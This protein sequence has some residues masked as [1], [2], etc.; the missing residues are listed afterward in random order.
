MS[1]PGTASAGAFGRLRDLVRHAAAALENRAQLFSV[2]LQEEKGRMIES[3]IWAAAAC[4]FALLFLI[5]VTATVILVFPADTRVYAA[6][7][8]ALLYLVGAVLAWMN[9]RAIRKN[10]PPPFSDTIAELKKD[11]EWFNSSN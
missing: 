10:S 1:E 7:G 6:A 9:L 5:V 2:E 4:L 3:F 8:F 11:R